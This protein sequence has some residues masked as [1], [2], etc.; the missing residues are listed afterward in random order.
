MIRDSCFRA[1]VSMALYLL[2]MLSDLANHANPKKKKRKEKPALLRV[3]SHPA[4]LYTY[5]FTVWSPA[6][7]YI[8]IT[9][10]YKSKG[11]QNYL[12]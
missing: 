6:K 10:H 12:W 7:M 9:L 3:H 11:Y 5:N 8:H 1:P 4:L 2:I